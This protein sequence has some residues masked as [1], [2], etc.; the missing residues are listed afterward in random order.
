MRFCFNVLENQLQQFP[1]SSNLNPAPNCQF[2]TVVNTN[3]WT[4][5]FP[6]FS[7]STSNTSHSISKLITHN[8]KPN[9]KTEQFFF[10]CLEC[11][12]DTGMNAKVV[13]YTVQS[14]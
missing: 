14:Q 9:Q 13:D 12:Q 6:I 2:E 11:W 5:L 1:F 7:R 3:I 10:I 4:I 8:W